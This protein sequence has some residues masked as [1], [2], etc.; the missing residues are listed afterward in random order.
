V[1]VWVWV[2]RLV[3]GPTPTLTQNHSI[4]K[5]AYCLFIKKKYNNSINYNFNK[6]GNDGGSILKRVDMV[7]MKPREIKVDHD[8][9]MK[10]RY[11]IYFRAKFCALTKHRLNRPLASCKLGFIFNYESIVKSLM[12][13]SLP[14]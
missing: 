5:T 7:R 13:K 2:L 6:M 11:I 4:F 14:S 8:L 9:I 10:A 1:G 3:L 12:E